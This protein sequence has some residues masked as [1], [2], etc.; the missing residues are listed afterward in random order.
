MNTHLTLAASLLSLTT[1]PA[2]AAGTLVLHL[3]PR[4]DSIPRGGTMVIDVVANY[5]GVTSGL[6]IAGWK[7]D[8]IGSPNGTLTGDVNDAVFTHGVNNG[9]PSSEKLQDFAGGQLPLSLGGGNPTGVLGTLSF[10]DSGTSIDGYVVQLSI[11][12][13]WEP[14]GALNVYINASG[15]QSRTGACGV[16]PCSGHLVN[17]AAIPFTVVPAPACFAQIL[18]S[19]CLLAARRRR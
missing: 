7:F 12:D 14:T 17:L 6:S 11:E 3:I 2:L 9:V 18:A 15:S 4:S 16:V 10:T 5:S 13:Y 19:A 8:I 1:S